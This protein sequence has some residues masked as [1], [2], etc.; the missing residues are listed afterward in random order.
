MRKALS[1][2]TVT[3]HAT[4]ASDIQR[5]AVMKSLRQTLAAWQRAAE[6]NHQQTEINITYETE[7][8][9]N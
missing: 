6:E 5:N 1:S 9:P 3:I 8:V 2:D 7:A 4:F